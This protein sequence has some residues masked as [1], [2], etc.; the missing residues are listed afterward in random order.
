M[1]HVIL[2]AGSAATN[3]RPAELIVDGQDITEHVLHE[4]FEIG[5]TESEPPAAQFYMQIRINVETLEADLPDA[6]IE[7]LGEESEVA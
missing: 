4:G 2:R 5:V 7:A 3:G 6:V 1:A